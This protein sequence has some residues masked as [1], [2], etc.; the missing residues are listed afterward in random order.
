MW[1]QSV[2]EQK[3]ELVFRPRFLTRDIELM[4]THY[5]YDM[6]KAKRRQMLMI[7][8][9]VC[10]QPRKS[11]KGGGGDSLFP[12]KKFGSIFQTRGRSILVHSYITNLYN[13]QP[14]KQAKK[15]TQRRREKRVLIS[16]NNHTTPKPWGD[17]WKFVGG[18]GGRRVSPVPPIDGHELKLSFS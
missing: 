16:M 9:L 3:H 6:I 10:R 2:L 5:N 8:L 4:H 13:K 14:S 17:I 7:L 15:S 11:R 12:L 1:I 18:G